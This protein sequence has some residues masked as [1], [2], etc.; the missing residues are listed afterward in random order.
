MTS[1]CLAVTSPLSIAL[2]CEN[3]SNDGMRRKTALSI[4]A[5]VGISRQPRLVLL[6]DAPPLIS[7]ESGK[8]PSMPRLGLTYDMFRLAVDKRRLAEGAAITFGKLS[9]TEH[10]R[11]D[12]HGVE[13]WVAFTSFPA[14]KIGVLLHSVI[15]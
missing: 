15:L 4:L 2:P 5:F 1:L 6:A 9:S 13:H 8:T 11:H 14:T 12:C 10:L 3:L 7:M